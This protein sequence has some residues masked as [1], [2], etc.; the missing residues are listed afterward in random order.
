MFTSSNPS[1]G[2]IQHVIDNIEPI[3]TG[4]MNSNL[5]MPFSELE[6]KSA[7]FDMSPDKA[8]GPDGQSTIFYQKYWHIIGGDV[9]REILAIL[10]E[11]ALLGSWNNTIITLYPQSFESNDD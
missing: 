8:P 3:V 10:N 2:I 9:A 6:I 7:F 5:C 11:N 4:E 1:P